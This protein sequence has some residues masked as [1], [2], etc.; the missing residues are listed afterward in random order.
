MV[1]Q[2]CWQTLLSSN[3]RTWYIELILRGLIVQPPNCYVN[4]LVGYGVGE[5]VQHTL[6]SFGPHSV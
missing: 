1:V 6:T 2:C 4:L 5:Y 3:N